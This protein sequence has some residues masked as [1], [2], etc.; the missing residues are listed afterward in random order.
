MRHRNCSFVCLESGVVST[1]IRLRPLKASGRAA[2]RGA[3]GGATPWLL[4]GRRDLLKRSEYARCD[5]LARNKTARTA[6]L[7]SWP[8]EREDAGWWITRRGTWTA[9]RRKAQ[10][11]VWS[12]WAAGNQDVTRQTPCPHL[13]TYHCTCSTSLSSSIHPNTITCSCTAVFC[14]LAHIK[15]PSIFLSSMRFHASTSSIGR[16]TSIPVPVSVSVSSSNLPR[17]TAIASPPSFIS[18]S[19]FSFFVSSSVA[20]FIST[21]LCSMFPFGFLL[22]C[23]K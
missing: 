6:N 18:C 17:S 15:Q 8:V 19:E 21:G 3:A 9:A 14:S 13:P 23:T 16:S 2:R 20:A 11:P 4:R 5:V 12:V 22:V 10:P 1:R 7:S